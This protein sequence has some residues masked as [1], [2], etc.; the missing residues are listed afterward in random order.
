MSLEEQAGLVALSPYCQLHA[1]AGNALN[2]AT[3]GI[4]VSK[5]TRSFDIDTAWKQD[6]G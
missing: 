2:G 3:L 6:L 4:I 5:Y 1:P